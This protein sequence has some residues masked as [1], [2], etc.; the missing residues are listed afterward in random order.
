MQRLTKP[1]SIVLCLITVLARSNAAELR[2][3]PDARTTGSVV[4]LG[5]VADVLDGGDS[6][7]QGL[8]Q[9]ELCPAPAAG[10][11]RTISV[12]EIQDTLERRGMNMLAIRITGG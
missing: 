10:K 2:L 11:L 7:M 6:E 12:R 4:R 3:R 8:A 5:D 9:I 1:I